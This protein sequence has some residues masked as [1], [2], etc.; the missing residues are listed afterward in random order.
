[1]S[2]FYLFLFVFIII[3]LLYFITVICNKKKKNRIF[4]TNQAK[5][6]IR[7]SNLDV[8]SIDKNVFSYVLS[9]S[10]SFI[11]SF[12]FMV[13]EFFQNYIVKLFVSFIVLILLII[14]IY[15]II[16]LFYKKEGK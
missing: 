9:L 7:F 5:L 11:V 4:D 16:G 14:I 1:M 6:I 2:K 3:Y 13:S 15:K 12:T 8:S 10:N